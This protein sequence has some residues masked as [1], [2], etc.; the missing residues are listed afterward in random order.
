ME[1]AQTK[2]YFVYLKR[3]LLFVLFDLGLVLKFQFSLVFY[4]CFITFCY[5]AE[6]FI[7]K[8]K[9]YK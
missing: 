9:T 6:A 1:R 3:F 8:K 2:P 4:I 5:L 7:K